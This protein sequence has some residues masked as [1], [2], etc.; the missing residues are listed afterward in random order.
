MTKIRTG[1]RSFPSAT[2]REAATLETTSLTTRN[3][4]DGA[5]MEAEDGRTLPLIDPGS[6][7]RLGSIADSSVKDVHAAVSAAR[8]AFDDGRWSDLDPAVRQRLLLKLADLVERDTDQLARIETLDTGKPLAESRLDVEEASAVLRYFAGWSDKA[9]GTVIP[10]PKQ[11]FATTERVP[12]GVC[13][14]ITPW[15][16]P[17]PILTYKVAPALA[18]GNTVVAKPS[19]LASASSVALASLAL[20]AGI[21]PGVFNV[22]TG[23]REAGAALA[24]DRR[25][26][27][28]AFT[29]STVTGRAVLRA[30]AENIIPAT[31]EL[32]GKSTQLVF[33]DADLELA[34]NGIAEGIW[35]HAGQICVA[36]SR[37]LVAEGVGRRLMDLLLDRASALVMGHG[38][39]APTTFGP[40]ISEAQ[41]SKVEQVILE[42]EHTGAAVVQSHHELPTAGYFVRPT[43][44]SNVTDD[45]PAVREE[46]FGPVLVVQTFQTEAEA[47]ERANAGSYG[48]AAGVWTSDANCLRRTAQS[49]QAGTVWANGYGVFHPTFPFGGMKASG[50]GRELGEQAVEHYTQTRTTVQYLR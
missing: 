50:F 41:R 30:A 4:I 29:G 22:V 15:N 44:I 14:A 5:Q 21:P 13:G 9:S 10:A 7:K 19:E 49:L 3:V 48:L 39:D 36:G 33:G 46:I 24:A 11:Y 43:V 45:H 37:V 47:I 34:A 26:D 1:T 40:L 17:L 28:L 6:G 18:F 2:D 8:R 20:E 12:L 32:G 38:L 16:Y 27:K 35:T 31:V 23:G 42:S 25:L